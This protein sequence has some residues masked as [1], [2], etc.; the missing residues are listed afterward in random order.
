MDTVKKID[1]HVHSSESAWFSRPPDRRYATPAEL[2]AIYDR[3]GVERGVLLPSIN[4]EGD[5][6]LSSNYEMKLVADKYPDRFSWFCNIDP[7]Q[8]YNAPETDFTPYLLTCME[9]GARGVGEICANLPFDDP[10]M[11]NLFYHCEKNGLPVIFHI[12]NR[13]RDYGIVDSFGLPGL[14]GALAGFPKLRFFG[15]SQKF[16]A[17]ISGDLKPE[18]RDGYPTG[19]VA[20]GGRLV[21]LMRTYPN[22]CCDLSAGS[23]Y[24]AMTRDPAFGYAFMEEFSDR[25]YYGTDICD[26]ANIGSPMLK[27]AAFLDEGLTTGRLSPEAYYRIS[28]GNAEKVLGLV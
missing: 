3:I 14:E 2:I 7:R 22:L 13:G 24:N 21:T 20:P 10:L 8:G 26:P 18:E 25:L 28:R 23:G 1:I 11:K 5:F 6:Q 17:E 27:L 4:V 12:G 19:P 9:N 15:H 16:W